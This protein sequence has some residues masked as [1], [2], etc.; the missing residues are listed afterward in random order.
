MKKPEVVKEDAEEDGDTQQQADQPSA[1][2]TKSVS[3]A[4]SAGGEVQVL[5]QPSLI[6]YFV[7]EDC[8]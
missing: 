5:H 3:T 6:I 7:F 4:S 8:P 2:L 1:S